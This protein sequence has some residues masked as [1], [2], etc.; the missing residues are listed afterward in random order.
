MTARSTWRRV[1]L[2][3]VGA[4]ILASSLFVLLPLLDLSLLSAAW[5]KAVA[6]P[7]AL[8]G[9]LALYLSAFLLRSFLWTRVLP[10]LS[11]S[12]ALAALHVSLGGNHILPLRLGEA[13]RV[14]SVVRRAGVSFAPATASTIML[15]AADIL[16]VGTLAT[17][18]GP[19]V[20]GSVVG[21][22][23]WLLIVPP[24]LVWAAGMFWLTRLKRHGKIKIKLPL[25]SL[26]TL[27]TTAW[28]LESAVMWQAASW[29]G[30]ELTPLDAVLV[31]AVT[32]AAQVVALTPGGIGT[33][34]AAATAGLVGLG[35]PPEIA[36]AAAVTAHAV[37]T[38]YALVAGTVGLFVPSPG[39]L[40]RLRLP[41]EDESA[42]I[43]PSSPVAEKVILFMPA[44]DEEGTIADV[45]ARVPDSVC[46]LPVSCLVV[47]DGSTD[48][49][50]ERARAAGAEVIS[51]PR[52]QGLGA[53]VRQGFAASVARGAAVIAFCDAD[54]E[55]SPE[56]LESIARPIV[57]GEAHYVVGS[58]FAGR[59]DR[60]LPH[61]RLGNTILTKLLRFVAR[62]P[63]TD[64]QSGYRALSPEAAA[65]AELIHDFNYA[66]VLTLDLIDKGFGYTEVPITYRFREHGNSFVKLGSYL[67]HVLP[68][69]YRE[70]NPSRTQR[71]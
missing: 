44:F 11:F 23:T 65:A 8:I 60:M 13:L 47:D 39:A 28:V 5:S 54:G 68:A 4:V 52:N 24:A 27:S 70:L 1:I 48:R 46:G 9:V 12:H 33:Y 14:S 21:G 10:G 53:A 30:F 37:K 57:E 3:V 25:L 56:E 50:A 6:A 22:L 62:R 34:E 19:R 38:A 36:L 64:G 71:A 7:T 18:L 61:R 42:P 15:R 63:I 40:G 26:V 67:R 51:L 41:P 58:R 43:T 16:A 49:T 17:A 69:I 35:A 2:P 31:T 59:I 45:I 66:Q 29:A 32:I 55:Y 20:V